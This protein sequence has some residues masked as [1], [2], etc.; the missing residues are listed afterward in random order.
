M[1]IKWQ[2][3]SPEEVAHSHR[4]VFHR[5]SYL[6]THIRVDKITKLNTELA[7]LNDRVQQASTNATRLEHLFKRMEEKYQE[8]IKDEE[9]L[10]V[11]QTEY[12]KKRAEQEKVRRTVLFF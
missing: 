3:L 2:L 8:Q 4:S 1:E 11:F 7:S 5:F 12:L 9:T 10:A 6:C